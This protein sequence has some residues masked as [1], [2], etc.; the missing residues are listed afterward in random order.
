MPVADTVATTRLASMSPG[1]G[2]SSKTV[3]GV[4]LLHESVATRTTQDNQTPRTGRR[5]PLEHDAT[6]VDTMGRKVSNEDGRALCRKRQHLIGPVFGQ[7]KDGR[8][9][10]RRA[11]AASFNRMTTAANC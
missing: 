11:S 10:R 9:A 7:I 1:V 8:R 3:G 4:S 6:L 5:G 2:L